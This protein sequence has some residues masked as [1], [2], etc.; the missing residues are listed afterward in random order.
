MSEAVATTPMM[1][2]YLAMRRDLPGDVI[3]L[4]RLGD[5]YEMFFEDAK[6]AAGIL[7]VSLTKRNGI[8]MCGVPHHAAQS[9]IARL[10]RAGK[11][12]AIGEQVGEPVPGKLVAREL[13]EVIS[14]GTVTDGRF[15]DANKS[16]YLAA[17]FREGK[18]HGLAY[19]D[20]STG[21]FELAEFDSLDGLNDELTRIAPSELLYADDQ[22]E[23]MES[24]G[25]PK[26][27]QICESYLFLQDQALH[28]LTQHFKVQSLDGYGCGHLTAALGA[29]GAIMQ[30]LQFQLR[31][32]VSHIKRLRVASLF[33]GVWVDTASQ[34]HLELVNSRSGAEHTLLHSLNRTATPMGARK[35][36]RWVLHPLR[37]LAQLVSRQDVVGV[38]LQDPM[39]LGQL[40]DMLKDIRDLERTAGRLSQ[41]SGNARDLL[42]L[43]QALSAVPALKLLMSE[44][45]SRRNDDGGMDSLP[46]IHGDADD[47]PAY[48]PV[49]P[50]LRTLHAQLHDLTA[51]AT[52][53]EQA[54][55]EEPP[56]PIKE[57]GIFRN[58]YL[59]LLDEFRSASTQ[60]R[61]WIAK[62]QNDEIDRTG[63]KSLKIKYNAVFGYFIEITKSNLDS[64]PKDYTRKQ[65]TANGERFIT[66]ELKRMEDKILGADEK[67]KALEY[68]EFVKLRSR[69]M[70][71][72]A[73]IQETAE[74]LATLDALCSLAE[75]ARLFNYTRPLLDESRTLVIRDGRHPVLDQ[76]LAGDRF[77][78]ND[79]YLE[80]VENRVLI[81]T[82]P[83]M[84]GKSTYIRQVALLTL[85]AQIGS[86]VP[87]TTMELGL[88][89]RIFTRIGA[90]DDLSRGQSTFM[91][92]M[93][94]T[95]MILNNATDRSL[96]ILDEIGRGTSTFD[97]LS[98]AW[99]VAEHLHNDLGSRT[100]F[101]THYHELTALTATCRA[102]K[103][104]NV[105]VKEW[106]QQIIFLRKI[107]AGSAEK[108]YG[109]QVAR[110]AGL[111]ESVLQRARQILERLEAGH[112]P[113][114]VA[115]KPLPILE[116]IETP[117]VKK[118]T[119]RK[120]KAAGGG[121]GANSSGN[122]NAD[123]AGAGA[124]A[125]VAEENEDELGDA[126][127]DSNGSAAVKKK[128]RIE[129]TSV[130]S[131]AQMSLFG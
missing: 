90:S 94:E 104:Y 36:R 120:G 99:S 51:M 75:T 114:E 98:I 116:E 8:P 83:N 129:K 97:G 4:F 85:M 14:A 77:V 82:G 107:I 42:V 17:I 64:V 60:G 109:I 95:S 21:E 9:Y 125:S 101:A 1:K 66:D 63:I 50:L 126:P 49:V 131:E 31:K 22:R 16:H 81:I 34:S 44:C 117:V 86:Y 37:D 74:A 76:N 59:P 62:L 45:G 124:G 56:A 48:A 106:N 112:P 24:L 130:A 27:A 108:S 65:T 10:I 71:R 6:V 113:N 2:Q 69:A 119:R 105:A 32:D 39:L 3:L 92:E 128:L 58:G 110:L 40:R 73:E 91:V 67:G 87:A 5:F 26:S 54:I 57:G 100:L 7:N 23:L 11:R 121:A 127:D 13:S 93:N 33:D 78:P 30:Y 15:L 96:V 103:N 43:A 115:V 118:P 19:V 102:V 20:H 89:D 55:V 25:M 84:A 72:L 41:G 35:L 12:V 46:D 29:A 123:A 111:P 68:E 80:E 79:T 18:K 47:K 38:M 52:E 61:D 88:V 122:A 28:A 53:I 70:E